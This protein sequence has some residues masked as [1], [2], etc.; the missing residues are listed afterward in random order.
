MNFKTG[1]I[2]TVI[3]LWEQRGDSA[4]RDRERPR[5]DDR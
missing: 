3:L 5:I 4:K 1:L 2:A